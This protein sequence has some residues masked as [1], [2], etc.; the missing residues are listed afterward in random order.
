MVVVVTV[1]VL[2]VGVVTSGIVVMPASEVGKSQTRGSTGWHAVT[3]ELAGW[4]AL[5]AAPGVWGR[6]GLSCLGVTGLCMRVNDL[7]RV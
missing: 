4:H 6:W 5:T 3:V 7:P 1:V 2:V